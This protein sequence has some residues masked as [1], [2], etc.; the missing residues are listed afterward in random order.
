MN[1]P[2]ACVDE[3]SKIILHIGRHLISVMQRNI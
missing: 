2:I 3:M 1:V